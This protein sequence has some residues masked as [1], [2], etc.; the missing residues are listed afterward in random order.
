MA[1]PINIEQHIPAGS[2]FALHHRTRG[3]V[4]AAEHMRMLKKS[5]RGNEGIERRLIAEMIVDTVNLP[6]PRRTGRHAHR[7]AEQRVG[8]KQG[9]G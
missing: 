9:P 1:L 3:A 2:Q 8:V 4:T 7:Q 5:A 6:W